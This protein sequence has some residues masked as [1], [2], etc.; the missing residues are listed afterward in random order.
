MGP[1]WDANVPLTGG[2]SSARK[3]KARLISCPPED[4]HSFNK[5]SSMARTFAFHEV[6]FPAALDEFYDM[7]KDK[8]V[9]SV[10]QEADWEWWWDTYAATAIGETFR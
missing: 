10:V 9:P 8:M 7:L 3:R 2:G 4:Q 1:G 5:A 6:K